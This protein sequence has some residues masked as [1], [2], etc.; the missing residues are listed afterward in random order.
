MFR[1]I[2][3]LKGRFFLRVPF[4]FERP[5]GSILRAAIAKNRNMKFICEAENARDVIGMFVRDENGRKRF[6]RLADRGE[7]LADLQWRE[8]RVHEDAGFA[9]LHIGTIASGTAA[10][11]GELDGHKRKLKRKRETG[12]LKTLGKM[13]FYGDCQINE[14]PLSQVTAAARLEFPAAFDKQ[15]LDSLRL[16]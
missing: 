14:S 1:S 9:G 5:D 4:G 11:D 10:E 15:E 12:K 8:A 3:A 2:H 13:F 6:R 7:A 16:N